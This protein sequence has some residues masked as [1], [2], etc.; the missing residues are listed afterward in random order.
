MEVE[1]KRL[2]RLDRGWP[3]DVLAGCLDAAHLQL[4]QVL[5]ARALD[6]HSKDIHVYC[7][8]CD[9]VAVVSVA[10]AD[11]PHLLWFGSGASNCA[12]DKS[13]GPLHGNLFDAG[14][15]SDAVVVVEGYE[16]MLPSLA[17]ALWALPNKKVVL[18]AGVPWA[19]I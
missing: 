9:I 7:G 13:R 8:G 12:E 1:V 11:A 3:P 2:G 14:L 17:D 5:R 6:H 18:R 4:A 16:D 15:P 10:F 19:V